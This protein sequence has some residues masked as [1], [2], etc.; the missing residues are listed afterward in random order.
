MNSKQWFVINDKKEIVSEM[1]NHFEDAK[2][3]YDTLTGNY[4]ICET[5]YG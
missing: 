4:I 1:F 2:L 5:V 3:F